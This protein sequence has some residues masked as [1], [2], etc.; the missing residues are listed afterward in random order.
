MTK[1]ITPASATADTTATPPAVAAPAS[2][3]A[4]VWNAEVVETVVETTALAEIGETALG[5]FDFGEMT[6]AGMKALP[7]SLIQ[8]PYMGPLSKNRKYITDAKLPDK[9]ANPLFGHIGDFWHPITGKVYDGALGFVG[10]LVAVTECYQERTPV[11]DNK[12]R[13]KHDPESDYVRAGIEKTKAANRAKKDSVPFGT[14]LTPDESGNF[15]FQT[16]DAMVQLQAIVSDDG[17]GGLVLGDKMLVIVSFKKTGVPGFKSYTTAVR[18]NVTLPNGQTVPSG[19]IPLLANHFRLTSE[20]REVGA[21]TWHVAVM[22]PLHGDVSKSI[23]KGLLYVD[24][25]EAY[26]SFAAGRLQADDSTVDA[27]GGDAHEGGPGGAS[28][29]AA[30][31]PAFKY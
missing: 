2:D 19:H 13:G 29:G 3:A 15:L 26:K 22:K 27:A 1:K 30:T 20:G 5:E 12:F 10:V 18:G 31:D 9:T 24:A 28:A 11:P 16:Y 17:N 4:P 23:T 8:V 25:C 6:G 21:N 14:T 7:A